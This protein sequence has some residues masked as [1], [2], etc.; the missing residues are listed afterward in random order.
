MKFR[1]LLLL[2]LF[3]SVVAARAEAPTI[4]VLGDSLSAGLGVEDGRGW[5][6]L[7]QDRLRTRNLPYRVVNASISGD[8]TRSALARLPDALA[9]YRPAVV[10][11]ELGGNDGLRGLSL[12]AMADNLS[13]IVQRSRASGAR[14]LLLA[15]RLPPNYGPVYV[16]RFREVYQRVAAQQQVPLVSEFLADVAERPELMQDD[17]IHPRAVAQGRMLD[18]VWPRLQPLLEGPGGA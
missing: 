5:V 3:T 12:D 7:L 16:Q 4:L 10:I 14:V 6:A 15:V 18:N 13:A 11:V 2:C 9:R 1:F 17:G 8:T